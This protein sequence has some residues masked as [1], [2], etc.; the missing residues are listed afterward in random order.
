[1]IAASFVL[2]VVGDPDRAFFAALL[3]LA[4]MALL[5]ICR[6]RFITLA[7]KLF[8]Q[9]SFLLGWSC[10]VFLIWVSTRHQ[11]MLPTARSALMEMLNNL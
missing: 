8:F 7:P 9:S 11:S 10:V 5:R 1:M 6:R 3:I 2:Y 4:Q